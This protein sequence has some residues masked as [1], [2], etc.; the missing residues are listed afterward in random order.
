MISVKRNTAWES[1]T[2]TC[3][4][5]TRIANCSFRILNKANQTWVI[6]FIQLIFCPLFSSALRAD[7]SNASDVHHLKLLQVSSEPLVSGLSLSVQVSPAPRWRQHW[8][9]K[10]GGAGSAACCQSLWATEPQ[11]SMCCET[12][13]LFLGLCVFFYSPLPL[14]DA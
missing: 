10:G 2:S 14:W 5:Y 7:G 12:A 9:H 3:F 13:P 11:L 6:H 8:L 1:E 4:P